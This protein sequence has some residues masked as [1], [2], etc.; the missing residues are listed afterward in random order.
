MVGGWGQGLQRKRERGDWLR[1]QGRG[2]QAARWA[3]PSGGGGEEGE[4]EREGKSE[5]ERR[6]GKGMWIWRE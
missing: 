4:S 1:P 3:E 5:L 2:A 6:R